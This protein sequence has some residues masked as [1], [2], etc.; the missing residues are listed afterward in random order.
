MTDFLQKLDELTKKSTKPPWHIAHI[1]ENLDHA[2]LED[3][4]GTPVANVYQRIDQT[5][6]VTLVNS[7][8]QL[9]ARLRAA[10]KAVTDGMAYLEFYGGNGEPGDIAESFT[11]SIRA[12]RSAKEKK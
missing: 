5:F 4:Y 12:W 7:Y 1:D 11:N 10:E 9:A 6:I 3:Q 2:E 8:E